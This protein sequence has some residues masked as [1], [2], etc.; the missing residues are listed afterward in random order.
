MQYIQVIVI[1]PPIS[2]YPLAWGIFY[3]IKHLFDCETRVMCSTHT[4]RSKSHPLHHKLYQ[5][6]AQFTPNPQIDFGTHFD[7]TIIF[8]SKTELSDN[9]KIQIITSSHSTIPYKSSISSNSTKNRTQSTKF[10]LINYQNHS[11]KIT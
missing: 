7:K 3:I 1:F 4:S 2:P 8:P 9:L 5:I 11:P 6:H 10:H